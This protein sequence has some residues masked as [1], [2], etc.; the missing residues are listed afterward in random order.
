MATVRSFVDNCWHQEC[1]T[2][3]FNL[4]VKLNPGFHPSSHQCPLPAPALVLQSFMLQGSHVF[5]HPYLHALTSDTPLPMPFGS[6]DPSEW[7]SSFL[8]SVL[9]P[10]FFFQRF[11]FF[12]N[13]FFHV[14]LHF[15][16]CHCDLWVIP[17]QLF[18][19]ATDISHLG[20]STN[21]VN[22]LYL[23]LNLRFH[24]T[25]GQTLVVPIV[26]GNPPDI[27]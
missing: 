12:F 15:Q 19:T 25:F 23:K 22:L 21:T 10:V 3:P 24:P 20:S 4:C 9:N 17:T 1:S 16:S 2:N 14:L 27:I 7:C 6:P 11:L 18:C 8:T 5:T 13:L 26:A